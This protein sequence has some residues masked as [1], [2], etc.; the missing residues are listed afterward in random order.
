MDSLAIGLLLQEP[1]PQ[2]REVA[3]SCKIE[4]LTSMTCNFNSS[5]IIL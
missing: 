2:K 1:T 5:H 3:A 4:P